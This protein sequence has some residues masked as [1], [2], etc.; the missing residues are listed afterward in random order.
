[1]DTDTLILGL[2]QG[3]IT[4]I[5]IVAGA[6]LLVLLLL[7]AVLRLSAAIMRLGCV[8]VLIVVFVFAVLKMAG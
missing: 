5:A 6:A 4:S 2:T 3:D 8:V 1:M 7:G